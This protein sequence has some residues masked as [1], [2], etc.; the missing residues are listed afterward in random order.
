MFKRKR[1]WLPR[2]GEWITQLTRGLC[3]PGVG[4]YPR[5]ASGTPAQSRADGGSAEF[6]ASRRPD[7]IGAYTSDL[8]T[9]RTLPKRCR[10]GRI[11]SLA[12]C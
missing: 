10:N 7:T 11:M 4:R 12:P 9:Q 6:K 2:C 8:R 1:N 5:P 3:S